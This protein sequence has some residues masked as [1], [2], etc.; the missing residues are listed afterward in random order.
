MSRKEFVLWHIKWLIKL[1]INWREFSLIFQEKYLKSWCTNAVT[2]AINQEADRWIKKSQWQLLAQDQSTSTLICTSK[3]S[4][5]HAMFHSTHFSSGFKSY[6]KASGWQNKNH[7]QKCKRKCRFEV[8]SLCSIGSHS[9]KRWEGILSK[10]VCHIHHSPFQVVPLPV[11]SFSDTDR[12][13]LLQFCPLTL[14]R[15]SISIF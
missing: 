4:E 12:P 13:V 7:I 2:L 1:F 9:R 5:P 8:T 6:V 3:K 15:L 10:P 14:P 11:D